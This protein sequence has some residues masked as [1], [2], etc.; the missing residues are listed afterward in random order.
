MI[1]LERRFIKVETTISIVFTFDYD[2]VIRIRLVLLTKLL[3]AR[4]RPPSRTNGLSL[5]LWWCFTSELEMASSAGPKVLS[6]VLVA[7]VPNVIDLVLRFVLRT[8]FCLYRLS[9][10]SLL[11]LA[12]NAARTPTSSSSPCRA[13]A[14]VLVGVVGVLDAVLLMT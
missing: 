1:P 8:L 5:S 10:F 9:S 4:R 12:A 3:R 6:L 14:I 7:T 13:L 2:F 11:T